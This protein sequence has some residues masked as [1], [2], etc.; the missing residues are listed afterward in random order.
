ML[1]APKWAK[2]ILKLQDQSSEDEEQELP[3]RW[4]WNQ[5]IQSFFFDNK[6]KTTNIE[7]W[8]PKSW[9]FFFDKKKG[10]TKKYLK[11]PFISV[12]IHIHIHIH[13]CREALLVLFWGS[14][15]SLWEGEESLL[16]LSLS[17][18]AE[19]HETQM[20]SPTWHQKT[21]TIDFYSSIQ[22]PVQNKIQEENA[23]Q[24]HIHICMYIHFMSILHQ[25]IKRGLAGEGIA[26]T[27]GAGRSERKVRAICTVRFR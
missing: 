9:C 10:K 23:H 3:V 12:C 27:D 24:Q 11:N 5:D 15:S 2:K 18:I 6:R 22:F 8:A 7:W 16:S 4:E 26:G 21:N 13:I 19:R 25:M 1:N 20:I 14:F 17:E